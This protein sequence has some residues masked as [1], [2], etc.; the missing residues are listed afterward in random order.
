[1]SVPIQI[2]S[3]S[4]FALLVSIRHPYRLNVVVTRAQLAFV[5]WNLLL[6]LSFASLTVTSVPFVT[7]VHC[8]RP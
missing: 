5:M 1:M 8:T 7:A 6:Y 3:G 4:P 2:D